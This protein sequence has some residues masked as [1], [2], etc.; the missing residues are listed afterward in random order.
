M[1]VPDRSN[2]PN[3]KA[4]FKCEDC[5]K[6]T[7]I[8][9]IGLDRVCNGCFNDRYPDFECTHEKADGSGMCDYVA[10]GKTKSQKRNDLERHFDEDPE[11]EG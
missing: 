1:S 5:G 11:H 2:H 3:R 9:E 10:K 7:P 6:I 8:H 4:T